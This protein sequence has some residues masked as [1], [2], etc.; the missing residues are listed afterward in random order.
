MSAH[1]LENPH[2]WPVRTEGAAA[3][4]W[5]IV[6]AKC[7]AQP[8]EDAAEIDRS[9]TVGPVLLDRLLRLLYYR[10]QP[11]VFGFKPLNLFE[12]F[13][14]RLRHQP[15]G[16]ARSDFTKRRASETP[17]NTA[18]VGNRTTPSERLTRRATLVVI[19]ARQKEPLSLCV[20]PRPSSSWVCCQLGG[21][22][23]FDGFGEAELDHEGRVDTHGGG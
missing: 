16:R 3:S 8:S 22:A 7:G 10:A 17:I 5:V 23:A 19:A 6:P 20:Q 9:R 2:C 13:V 18:C 21:A 11:F 4:R 1:D 15:A 12:I 14:L